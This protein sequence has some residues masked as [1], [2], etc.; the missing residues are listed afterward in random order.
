[1][2]GI[3]YLGYVID[4]VGIHVDLEKVQILKDWTIPQNIHELRSFLGLLNSYLWFILGFS[5]IAWP[6]NQLMKGNGKTIF[7]WTPTKQQ[8]FEQIKNKLC[9]APVLVLPDLHQPFEIETDA[10][11]YALGTVITQ[12]GHLVTFHSESFNDT[13]RRYSTYE[14]ELYVIMRALKQWRFYIL[15]REMI[16]LTE[17]KPLQFALT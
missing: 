1:M 12:S 15:G 9:T 14:K 13:V 17:H 11:N 8:A 16:I 5:H 10:S 4:S 7:K 3:K 6:L 2:T